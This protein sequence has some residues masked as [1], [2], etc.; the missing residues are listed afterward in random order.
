VGVVASG[1][2][3]Y[4]AKEAFGPEASYLKLGYTHPLPV[5][6]IAEFCASPGSFT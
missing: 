5:K 3:Y 6:K 4:F 2:A 1:C